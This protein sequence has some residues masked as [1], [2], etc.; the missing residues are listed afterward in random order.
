MIMNMQS[1]GGLGAG[2]REILELHV[3]I[4]W[5]TESPRLLTVGSAWSPTSSCQIHMISC[6]HQS[7]ESH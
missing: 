6:A 3:Y 5:D 1:F 2:S 4:H 7:F